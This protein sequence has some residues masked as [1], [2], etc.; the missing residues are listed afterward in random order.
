M[1]DIDSEELVPLTN[2]ATMVPP[3]PNGKRMAVTTAWRWATVGVRGHKIEVVRIGGSK[4][5]SREALGRFLKAINSPDQK[6]AMR[7]TRK[8]RIA[9]AERVLDKAGV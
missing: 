6:P 7:K 8:R 5:T 4:Y 1:I 3:R 9:A 2:V